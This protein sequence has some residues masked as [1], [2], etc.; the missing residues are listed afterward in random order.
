MR[1]IQDFTQS[2]LSILL[3]DKATNT[4]LRNLPVY[5][6]VSIRGELPP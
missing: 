2:R 3:Y 6:E 4:L 1:S 5:A